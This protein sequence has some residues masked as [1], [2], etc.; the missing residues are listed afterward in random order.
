MSFTSVSDFIHMNGHGLYVWMAYGAGLLVLSYNLIAPHMKKS[1]LIK[2]L[3][4]QLKRE[5]LTK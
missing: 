3:S 2:R 1:S 4:Q 5:K